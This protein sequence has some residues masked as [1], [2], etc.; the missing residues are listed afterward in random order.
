MGCKSSKPII[1]NNNFEFDEYITNEIPN[2]LTIEP[3]KIKYFSFKGMTFDAIPCNIYDGDR[4]SAVFIF[5]GKVIKYKCRCVDYD[6]P[7]T[8]LSLYDFDRYHEFDLAIKARNRFIELLEKSPNK[9]VKIECF[10]F[11]KYG[12]ILVNVY[13]N[14]DT[15]SINNIMIKENHGRQYGSSKNQ[16]F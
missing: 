14:V 4:F 15:E 11:D 16:E 7:K 8:K 13:N 2:L 10:D 12:R 9:L 5:N 6:T 3:D 1:E